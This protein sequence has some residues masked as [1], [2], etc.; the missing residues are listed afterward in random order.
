MGATPGVGENL[1]A[2]AMKA[3]A[4]MRVETVRKAAVFILEKGGVGLWVG[5][6]RGGRDGRGV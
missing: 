1:G 6:G 2:G 3:W 5:L 4:P